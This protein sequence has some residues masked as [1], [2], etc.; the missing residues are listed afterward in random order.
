MRGRDLKSLPEAV[1]LLLSETRSRL[2]RIKPG[3]LIEF[4]QELH[5]AG[6]P[7]IRQSVP[8]R[9][10]PGGFSVEPGSA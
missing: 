5:R 7:E 2:E 10:L 4:R 8:G 3:I 9:R 6:D 1:N